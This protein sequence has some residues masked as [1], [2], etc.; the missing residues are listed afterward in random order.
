MPPPL[1]LAYLTPS[2]EMGLTVRSTLLKLHSLGTNDSHGEHTYNLGSSVMDRKFNRLLNQLLL[3][4]VKQLHT[5]LVRLFLSMA[6]G[7]ILAGDGIDYMLQ[8][9]ILGTPL[10]TRIVQQLQ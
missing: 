5:P 1:V 10:A 6:R 9:V 8:A 4:W 3:S 2:L 7:L